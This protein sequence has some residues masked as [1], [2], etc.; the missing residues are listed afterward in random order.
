M[1]YLREITESDLKIINAFRND[2][3]LVDMLAAPYRFI[4]LESDQKW[5]QSYLNNREHNIRCAICLDELTEPVGFIYLLNINWIFRTADFG[6]MIGDGKHRSKGVGRIA[7][8]DMLRH[9]FVDLNL[10]RIQLRVLNN[11]INAI[12]LYKS[13]G[14]VEEGI[15]RQAIVKEDAYQDLILMSILKQDFKEKYKV[16]D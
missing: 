10:N 15:L 9:G 12:G 14:F 13:I 5:F 8:L 3:E 4:N 2:S 11:N 7:T 16:N 6:I 1:Q